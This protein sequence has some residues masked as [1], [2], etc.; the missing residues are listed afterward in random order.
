MT[1]G[2][3]RPCLSIRSNSRCAR[4]SPS[5]KTINGQ[6]PLRAFQAPFFSAVTG[7]SA[8]SP[9]NSENPAPFRPGVQ[10]IPHTAAAGKHLDH[11]HPLVANRP[12]A[13]GSAMLGS[14]S[15]PFALVWSSIPKVKDS[16][17]CSQQQGCGRRLRNGLWCGQVFRSLDVFRTAGPP[18]IGPDRLSQQ[19]HLQVIQRGR[20]A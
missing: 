1:A 10:N 17:L 5:T 20:Q 7:T 8:S 2:E 13:E 16:R 3:T 14:S 12:S 18:E 9:A 6:L 11:V 15:L 19:T 4:P